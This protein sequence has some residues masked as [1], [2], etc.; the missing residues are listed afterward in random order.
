MASVIV[1]KKRSAVRLLVMLM[2]AA[3]AALMAATLVPQG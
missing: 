2:K 3:V 1:T